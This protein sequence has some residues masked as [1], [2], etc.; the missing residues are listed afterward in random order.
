MLDAHLAFHEV[1]ENAQT[2]LTLLTLWHWPKQAL[3]TNGGDRTQQVLKWPT[4]L[5]LSSF[6]ETQPQLGIFQTPPE[7]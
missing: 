3:Y 7:L 4:P 2:C 1:E 5:K 6:T